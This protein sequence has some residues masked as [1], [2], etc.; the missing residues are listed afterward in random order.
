MCRSHTSAFL[1]LLLA[2]CSCKK[3][4]TVDPGSH[5]Q[6]NHRDS[7]TAKLTDL[8]FIPPPKAGYELTYLLFNHFFSEQIEPIAIFRHLAAS[9]NTSTAAGMVFD[10]VIAYH[11]NRGT[12]TFDE[13]S[14]VQVF[15][16]EQ[17]FVRDVTH[18]GL[19]DLVLFVEFEP[20]QGM[21]IIG[22]DAQH[23]NLTIKYSSDT[24]RPLMIL[25]P[26]ST[27]ALI[28]YDSLANGVF[29]GYVSAIPRRCLRLTG[30]RFVERAYDSTWSLFEQHVRDS[31]HQAYLFA[32]Q[33]LLEKRM[34]IMPLHESYVRALIAE[35]LLDTNWSEAVARLESELASPIASKLSQEDI[36]VLTALKEL[37][38]VAPYVQITS[39]RLD[40]PAT[41]TL[42]VL[43][44]MLLGH[45]VQNVLAT[46]RT[47]EQTVQ[48]TRVWEQITNG[49]VAASTN[50]D[51]LVELQRYLS[52]LVTSDRVAQRDLAGILRSQAS[53]DFRLGSWQDA[54][55]LFIQSLS[56]DSTSASAGRA[57]QMLQKNW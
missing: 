55:G 20:W 22:S 50:R 7:L 28:M 47:A 6:G 46:L 32:R 19:S 29:E 11:W 23:R 27:A 10:E 26:D 4:V 15:P 39:Q 3:I 51:V 40:E 44:D 42:S 36:V 38:L 41:I 57:K 18:D 25:A 31:T 24:S 34:T 43:N 52:V 54:K 37:P 30:D 17:V 1:L 56:F 48:S 12:K 2:F 53:V 16:V 49:I 33:V 13:R 9:E 35:S 5:P 14:I 8:N 45:G 21:S